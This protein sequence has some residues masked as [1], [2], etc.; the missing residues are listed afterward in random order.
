MKRELFDN[1]SSSLL[2]RTSI[3]LTFGVQ[4]LFAA[5]RI[6]FNSTQQ[7]QK[8]KQHAHITLLYYFSLI[9]GEMSSQWAAQFVV[10]FDAQSEFEKKRAKT[11]V[12]LEK[13]E[14]KT[15]EANKG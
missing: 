9:A 14:M 11:K 6:I 12:F 3:R 4:W 10:E 5:A 13:K 1:N 2:V 7:Q 15:N 8:Q